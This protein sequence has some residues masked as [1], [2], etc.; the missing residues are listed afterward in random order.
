[1]PYTIRRVGS[2]YV[3]RKRAGGR[4]IGSHASKAK[5]RRQIRAIYASK[6]RRR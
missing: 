1:M 6:G 2:R 4:R 3:V 5:A